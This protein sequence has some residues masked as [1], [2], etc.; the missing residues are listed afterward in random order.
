MTCIAHPI[1]YSLFFFVQK[2]NN[3]QH[4]EVFNN[5]ELGNTSI[6]QASTIKSKNIK[7]VDAMNNNNNNS[8]MKN[9]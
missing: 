9:P 2:P 1:L 3:H 5:V 6:I 4:I 7:V 8:H